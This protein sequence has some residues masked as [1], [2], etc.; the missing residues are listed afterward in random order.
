LLRIQ[1]PNY[2]Q[3]RK[4]MARWRLQVA[5]YLYTDPPTEVEFKEVDRNTGRQARKVY[6]VPRFLNPMD[7]TD[8]NYPDE[9]V[10][11]DGNNAQGRDIIFIGQPSPDMEP[12]DDEAKKISKG[13]ID[14][15][16]WTKKEPGLDFGE[17][18]IKNF[19]EKITDLQTGQ[20]APVS[21]SGI[22][23]RAFTEM[24][25]QVKALMEQNAR[26]QAQ[27]LEKPGRRTL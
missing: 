3:R 23:P 27:M 25:E 9:V 5:H 26:L 14:S 13:Y 1:G 22:D 15:G 20:A 16:K 2:Y 21:T 17:S 10:V 7:P 12:I 8:C 24:Q 4:I 19:M 11:S 6:P 18:L